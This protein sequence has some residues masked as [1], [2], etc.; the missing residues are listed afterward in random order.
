MFTDLDRMTPRQQ[1]AMLH[2]FCSVALGRLQKLERGLEAESGDDIHE[3]ARA[4]IVAIATD[5]LRQV[6]DALEVA[7]HE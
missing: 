4:E 7:S 1:V 5:H 2:T 3:R 6:V